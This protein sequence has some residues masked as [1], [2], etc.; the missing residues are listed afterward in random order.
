MQQA[1]RQ[2]TRE[3]SFQLLHQVTHWQL[4]AALS[5]AGLAGAFILNLRLCPAGRLPEVAAPFQHA[6]DEASRQEQQQ[7]AHQQQDEQS[8]L[9]NTAEASPAAQQQQQQQQQQ[10]GPKPALLQAPAT[11]QQQQQEYDLPQAPTPIKLVA[12]G[13]GGT[14]SQASTPK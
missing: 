11:Q 8:V 9:G 7:Q 4:R 1:D 6:P 14:D 13:D 2:V 12:D 10:Q 3:P 5:L